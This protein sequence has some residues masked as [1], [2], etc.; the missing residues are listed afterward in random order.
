MGGMMSQAFAGPRAV[1]LGPESRDGCE[2][3]VRPAGRPVA[4]GLH[5]AALAE[6]ATAGAASRAR[7]RGAAVAQRSLRSGR[8]G[9]GGVAPGSEHPGWLAGAP[10]PLR[11]ARLAATGPARL[12]LAGAGRG[13]ARAGS[14]RADAG[15]PVRARG[16]A[17]RSDGVVGQPGGWCG[18]ARR[19]VRCLSVASDGPAPLAHRPRAAPP[20]AALGG[21]RAAEVAA[22]FRSHAG[23]A[24]GARR[25]AVPAA[26][27]GARRR[28]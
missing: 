3:T 24:A 11:P 18:P 23:V 17:G 7:W 27:M 8:Q 26:A 16:A 21:G 14:P 20:R 25:H 13:P 10:G 19:F 1:R 15:L 2:C 12:D 5:E 6:E 4:G 9:R 28:G 22:P